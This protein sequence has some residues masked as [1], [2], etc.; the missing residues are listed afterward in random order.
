MFQLLSFISLLLQ[1]SL[2][3]AGNG[4]ISFAKAKK[5]CVVTALGNRKDDVPNILRAFAECSPGG[6]V[7]FPEN[8]SY[9]IATRLNPI[10][11]D[12]NIEW[13]GQWT[14]NF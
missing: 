14:V 2:A 8:Q 3:S 7:I 4:Q 13:R 12:V 9:W 1:I 6:T 5:E 11:H 10:L